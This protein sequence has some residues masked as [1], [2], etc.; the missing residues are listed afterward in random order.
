MTKT[1]ICNLALKR[2][3]AKRI[4]NFDTDQIQEAQECRL[5]YQHTV[6]SMLS[7]F[8]WPFAR[9]RQ[10]LSESTDTP[11]FEW[12]HRYVLPNDFLSFRA[13]YPVY[14]EDDIEDRPV[15]EGNYLLT[16]EDSV[17]LKY[18]KKC[19]ESEFTDLFIEVLA[20]Q[21]ALKLI[22]SICGTKATSLTESVERD[23][24][25]KYNSVR[26]RI[27]TTENQSGQSTWNNARVK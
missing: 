1:E 18:T 9:A 19:D 7:M 13:V 2:I 27:L 3:G 11:A 26:A 20:L 21:L 4:T 14:D 23:F 15:I 24:Y 25:R 22:P 17:D 8:D 5:F 6:N 16:N 10:S 12:D